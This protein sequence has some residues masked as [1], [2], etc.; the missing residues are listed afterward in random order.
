[1]L[2]EAAERGEMAA[3]D[4]LF[5]TLEIEIEQLAAELRRLSTEDTRRP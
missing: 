3:I 4:H 1:M 5:H 2:E